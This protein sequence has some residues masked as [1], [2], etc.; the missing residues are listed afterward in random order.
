MTFN[1]PPPSNISNMFRNWLNGIA[2]KD[3]GHIRVGV[4]ALL[5]A[6]WT[7]RNDFCL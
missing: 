4:H 5:W 2:K 6:I 3:K 1:L 7:I